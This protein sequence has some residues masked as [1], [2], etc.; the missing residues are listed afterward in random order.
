MPRLEAAHRRLD[1]G[2]VD[3]AHADA[4]VEIAA[5]DQPFAQRLH[6][7]VLGAEPQPLR[8]RHFRPSAA[9]DDLL[10]IGRPPARWSGWSPA[11]GSAATPWASGRLWQRHRS[12]GR[13]R[14]AG[15]ARS[16]PAAGR[17]PRR[18]PQARPHRS[19]RPRPGS[20][21]DRPGENPVPSL[22]HRRPIRK[23]MNPLST[24]VT[25]RQRGSFAYTSPR[26]RAS[27]AA[28][29]GD[30]VAGSVRTNPQGAE[31][32]RSKIDPMRRP[33]G[34][35]GTSLRRKRQSPGARPGLWSNFRSETIR[36]DTGS[37]RSR[38]ARA[39]AAPC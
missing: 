14:P 20:R 36:A 8:R 31:G 10:R 6:A 30:F 17:R 23:R 9:R 1:I 29:L 25:R 3:L 12:P 39:A 34:V 27:L 28:G 4:G 11:T 16:V 22:R 7:G 18:Q 33:D 24:Q 38:T 35:A 15:C 13:T 2:I 21:G 5:G 26:D 32:R 37:G 19:R